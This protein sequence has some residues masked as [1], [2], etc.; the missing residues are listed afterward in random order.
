MVNNMTMTGLD[1]LTLLAVG[2]TQTAD[3]KAALEVLRHAA[4]VSVKFAYVDTPNTDKP[5]LAES[6]ANALTRV[7]E[8]TPKAFDC[9]ELASQGKLREMLQ[10]FSA[11][12][13][14]LAHDEAASETPGYFESDEATKKILTTLENRRRLSKAFQDIRKFTWDYL[15]ESQSLRLSAPA[16]YTLKGPL[17]RST[18][19]PE[20][21]VEPAAYVMPDFDFASEC[22]V[23][24]HFQTKEDSDASHNE[25]MAILERMKTDKTVKYPD[26]TLTLWKHS[27]IKRGDTIFAL[28]AQGTTEWSFVSNWRQIAVKLNALKF[29]AKKV[30][31]VELL[32]GKEKG[33]KHI[34]PARI[35]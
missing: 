14:T 10:G 25:T 13:S 1:L 8:K 18:G 20:R 19:D 7:S 21:T 22:L 34:V 23:D 5:R 11:I 2:S 26:P 31:R 16:Y 28:R 3:E 32:S 4:E 35:W 27:S 33:N 30:E 24:N 12:A 9:F 6:F 15:S 29:A 17:L